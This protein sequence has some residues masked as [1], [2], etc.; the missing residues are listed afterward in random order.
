M[1]TTTDPEVLL[2]RAAAG[3]R[4][5]FAVF[6]DQTSAQVYRLALVTTGAPEPAVEVCRTT[7][8]RAWR[9]AGQYDARVSTPIA[10]L[11]GLARDTGA[12]LR[13]AA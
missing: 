7:Y 6:Y 8:L 12:G 11:L 2:G 4:E 10:W 3:D 9:L 13:S 1:S 5:A